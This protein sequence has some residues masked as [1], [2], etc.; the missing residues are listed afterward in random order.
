MSY[1]FFIVIALLAFVG[2][3]ALSRSTSAQPQCVEEPFFSRKNLTSS[4]SAYRWISAESPSYNRKLQ[5]FI[6]DIAR[7]QCPAGASFVPC[8]KGTKNCFFVSHVRAHMIFRFIEWALCVFKHEY[9]FE[10]NVVSVFYIDAVCL[11][12]TLMMCACRGIAT[13]L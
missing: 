7:K 9:C 2:C 8:Q 4:E 5:G 3:L 10:V 12:I 11:C 1:S 13:S 6:V